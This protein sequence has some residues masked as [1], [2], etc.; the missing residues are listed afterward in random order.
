MMLC[1][2]E[3]DRPEKKSESEQKASRV[4]NGRGEKSKTKR[5]GGRSPESSSDNEADE[6]GASE[7]EFDRMSQVQVLALVWRFFNII[8]VD[9]LLLY[10]YHR[11]LREF[12]C[13]I[14]TCNANT[15][16]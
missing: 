5:N 2:Q 13:K 11:L 4:S 8:L 16:I 12:S 7:D 15:F 14:K 1:V 10:E 6:D 3:F 9:L